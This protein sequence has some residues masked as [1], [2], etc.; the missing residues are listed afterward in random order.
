[1]VIMGY[2]HFLCRETCCLHCF[3]SLTSASFYFS[4]M[5]PDLSI[6][7][8]PAS[9]HPNHSRYRSLPAEQQE[10]GGGGLREWGS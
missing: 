4:G 6:S 7:A 1:M 2:H 10:R 9:C 5:K 8:A 3:L